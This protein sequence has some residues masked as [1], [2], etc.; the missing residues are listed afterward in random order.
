MQAMPEASAKQASAAPKERRAERRDVS[1][2]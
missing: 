2:S 1:A